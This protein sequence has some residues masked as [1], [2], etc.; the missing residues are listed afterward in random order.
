MIY[1]LHQALSLVVEEGVEARWARHERNGRALQ[2]GLEAMGLG[3]HAEEKYRL[4]VLTTVRIPE[5]VDDAAVRGALLNDYDIEVGGGLGVLKGKVWRV[6]LMGES[7]NEGN[8]LHFLSILGKLLTD[9]GQK[10]DIKAGLDA[11]SERL[12]V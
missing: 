8:V 3:L 2:N 1:A 9:H 10:P 6:G 7:S 4:P 11:A 12:K 5:G